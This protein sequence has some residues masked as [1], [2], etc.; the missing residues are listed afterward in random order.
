MSCRCAWGRC[1]ATDCGRFFI[2][3]GRR[4]RQKY[5]GTTCAT[6]TRVAAHRQ[7]SGRMD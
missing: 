6:R 5:C 3:T 1:A 2:D 4:Q 7:R